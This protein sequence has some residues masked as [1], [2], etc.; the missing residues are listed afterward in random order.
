MNATD[1]LLPFF[2]EL[3][4]HVWLILGLLIAL[5]MIQI[6]VI[7][8]VKN[9]LVRTL[10]FLPIIFVIL[11]V[12]FYRSLVPV[13][14]NTKTI[15]TVPMSSTRTEHP[16]PPKMIPSKTGGTVPAFTVESD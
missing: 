6:L 3:I 7:S 8:V 12:V 15:K 2:Q 13:E 11:S 5:G 1:P 9:P 10:I 14:K 4:R 16:Q